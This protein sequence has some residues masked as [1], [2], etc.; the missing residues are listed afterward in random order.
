LT[1]DVLK[2]LKFSF[3]MHLNG[4]SHHSARVTGNDDY[5]LSWTRKTD[6][7]PN[8][9]ITED[10]LEVDGNPEIRLD[11][12]TKDPD[13]DGFCRA[14]NEWRQENPDADRRSATQIDAEAILAA[15]D[16]AKAERA[17]KM[18]NEEVALRVLHDAYQRLE[19]LGWRNAIYCPKDGGTFKAIEAGSTGI[20]D[21]I[22]QGEWP[23]GSWWCV[24]EGD[25][26]P[27]RPILF[28]PNATAQTPKAAP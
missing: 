25:M 13:L 4:G 19:E 20:H 3:R 11:M 23:K 16:K 9:L 8:Y 17:E 22:Y 6:G 10:T 12:H 21:C 5:G 7:S 15:A 14:Y 26:A 28:K 24:W 1:P 18:P 27:S 2:S